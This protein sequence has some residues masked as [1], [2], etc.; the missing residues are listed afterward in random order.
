MEFRSLYYF[1]VVAREENIT[2]AAVKLHMTQPT[3]SRQLMQLEEQ[4]DTQL[5]IRGKRKIT[6]TPEGMLLRRRAEDIVELVEKTE[7]D[8]KNSE[9]NMVGEIMI[10][11]AE[12]FAAHAFLPE[13]ISQFKQR[14][15]QITYDIYTG[16][17]DLIKERLEKGLLDIGLLLEPVDIEQYHFIRLPQREVWGL[18]VNKAHPLAEKEVIVP[19]D[20]RD[21]PLINTKRT[22]V[23]NEI[24]S[25]VKTGYDDLHFIATYNMVSNAASLVEKGIG[26]VIATDGAYYHH[27][28]Q[29]VKFIPFQPALTSGVVVV[30]KKHQLN[31]PALLKF[32]ERIY[33]AVNE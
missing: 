13:I 31:Q 15:P 8:L 26:S 11:S 4:L 20:L 9:E 29:N 25:W 1:L 28:Y 2:R 23:Q 22:I 12:C 30:W 32:I 7:R 6:L 27:T 5:L 3:L 33:H 10:G 18:L 14:Y 19:D 21:I 16:N 24:S 17:A